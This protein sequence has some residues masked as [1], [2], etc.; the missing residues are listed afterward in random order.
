MQNLQNH[1]RN[2]ELVERKCNELFEFLL[3]DDQKLSITTSGNLLVHIVQCIESLAK[4]LHKELAPLFPKLPKFHAGEQFDYDALGF[5][6]QALGLSK[7]QIKITSKLMPSLSEEK[8]LITPLLG[9]HES[10]DKH[11]HWSKAYQ[12][13]KHDLAN[14]QNAD[15]SAS[16]LGGKASIPS[17][18]QAEIEAAGAAFLLLTVAKSLPLNKETPYDQCDFTFG[19]DIFTATYARPLFSRF[20]GPMSKDCLQFFPNWEQKLFVVKDPERYI[21]YLRAK[22]KENN[23]QFKDAILSNSDFAS[24][25]NN[26]TEDRKRNPLELIL[27][28]YGQETKDPAQKKWS[29]RVKDLSFSVQINY[30]TAWAGNHSDQLKRLGFDPVVTLNYQDADHLY[31]YKKLSQDALSK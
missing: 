21:A 24:F 20:L 15:L 3:V 6:D 27:H 19:S 30:F 18:I 26:L 5:L 9:A 31:D 23:Q 4:D 28:W 11:P 22:T 14:S 8:R 12:S 7:K 25:Y 29:R 17:T 1:I 10:N 2:Y 16:S 13:N